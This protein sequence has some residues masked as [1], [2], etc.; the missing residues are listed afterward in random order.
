M[1]FLLTGEEVTRKVIGLS[2]G[3]MIRLFDSVG[4]V[5]RESGPGVHPIVEA[6]A[7][8]GQTGG[9]CRSIKTLRPPAL[10]EEATEEQTALFEVAK[11]EG[12][13]V[14][15]DRSVLRTSPP[16]V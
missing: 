6:A 10:P 7:G 9:M 8:R 1:Q 4:R 14:L 13:Y 2:H 15:P 5:V 11:Q 12:E 16:A 3:P